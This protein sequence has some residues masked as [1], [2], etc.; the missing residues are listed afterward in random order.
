MV[1]PQQPILRRPESWVTCGILLRPICR[2]FTR[3]LHLATT[4]W[5]QRAGLPVPSKIAEGA[6]KRVS[7]EN[8]YHPVREYL[9]GLKWDGTPR[10]D[11][12]LTEHLGVED[13]RVNRAMGSKWMIAAI[14]RILS[15]GC[16]V[17]LS[18]LS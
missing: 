9:E 17:E 8:I 18:A 16:K 15:P 12:W 11:N 3:R 4:E 10:L 7:Y 14:A 13:T 5:L 6:L 2:V 1:R